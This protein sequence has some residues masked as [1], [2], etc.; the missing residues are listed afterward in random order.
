M[1]NY[2]FI[3]FQFLHRCVDDMISESKIGFDSY[4]SDIEWTRTDFENAR[5]LIQGIF[6]SCQ[7][8]NG[9]FKQ[10]QG[11]STVVQEALENCYSVRK[12]EIDQ[13]AVKQSLL[14]NGVENLVENFDWKVKWVMGTSKMA[15]LREPLVQ[16]NLHCVGGSTVDFEADVDKLECLI[17]ELERVRSEFKVHNKY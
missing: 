5:D 10:L 2:S 12:Q 1:I 13:A 6:Q 3:D 14:E 7:K 8:A 11:V 15:L 17:N 9:D 4:S 16:I